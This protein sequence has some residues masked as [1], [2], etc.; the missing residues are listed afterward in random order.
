MDLISSMPS[1][2]QLTASP[3]AV[4]FAGKKKGNNTGFV[5]SLD[6]PSKPPVVIKNVQPKKAKG[7]H[8]VLW[9]YK[10]APVLKPLFKRFFRGVLP[11]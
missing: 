5:F 10:A 3:K 11:G 2:H 9:F 6:D 7:L 1:N 8:K 4:E